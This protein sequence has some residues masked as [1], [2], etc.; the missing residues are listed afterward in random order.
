MNATKSAA[1]AT[2][3]RLTIGDADAL[4]VLVNCQGEERADDLLV[5][6]LCGVNPERDGLSQADED[7]VAVAF[8]T[9]DRMVADGLLAK[10]I[11]WTREGVRYYYRPVG[12]LAGRALV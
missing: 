9:L 5:Q 2:A 3:Q 1:L 7:A 6:V 8:G 11:E 12:E 10:R 4:R